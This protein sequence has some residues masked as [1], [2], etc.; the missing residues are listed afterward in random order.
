MKTPR[1]NDLTGFLIG[2]NKYSRSF[3]EESICPGMCPYDL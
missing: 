1:V 2:N 3:N